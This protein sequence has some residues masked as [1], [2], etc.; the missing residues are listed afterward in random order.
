MSPGRF[1]VEHLLQDDRRTVKA[2]G[3]LAFL[4]SDPC[5]VLGSGCLAIRFSFAANRNI[6]PGK[7]FYTG[8]R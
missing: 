1:A 5:A 7:S 8:C 3:C 4:Y 6:K 2:F